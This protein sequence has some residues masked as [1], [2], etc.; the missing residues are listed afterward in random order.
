ML[1]KE[2]KLKGAYIIELEPAADER[3][4][5]ARTYCREEFERHGLNPQIAQCNLSYNRKKGT[6]RGMHYQ[7]APRAEAKLVTCISGSIY[8]VIIDLRP[9]SR[10]YCEWLAV[11]LSGRGPRSRIPAR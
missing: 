4:Y 7:I 5:F 11:K 10:T 1:F 3:G 9:D 2:A 6:L 8:D